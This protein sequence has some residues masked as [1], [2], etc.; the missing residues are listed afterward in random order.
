MSGS[1][2]GGL[3]GPA[4]RD[5]QTRQDGR[6]VPRDIF[7]CS[8][9]FGVAT[10]GPA[11]EARKLPRGTQRR[12]GKFRSQLLDAENALHALNYLW[13]GSFGEQGRE[14]AA[15]GD[16]NY[17]EGQRAMRE[18]VLESVAALG[19]PP[20]EVDEA[21][22]LQQLRLGHHYGRTGGATVVYDSARVS[23]PSPGSRPVAL[24]DLWGDGGEDFVKIFLRDKVLPSCDVQERLREAPPVAYGDPSL[25]RTAVYAEL[26]QRLSDGGVVEFSLEPALEKADVFFVGKSDGRQRMVVDCRRCNA[27]WADPADVA[28][29]TGETLSRLRVPKGQELWC[30]QVDIKDAFWHMEM[31]PPMRRYF[32]LRS[33]RAG[34]LNIKEINGKAVR[35][36]SWIQVRLRALPMGW[37]WA[38]W[39]C[40]AV[41]ERR[42]V[43]AGLPATER[44][45]DGRAVPPLA[46]GP[47][48]VYV[49]NFAVFGKTEQEV[50]EKLQRVT[51]EL[52]ASGLPLHQETVS[53]GCVKLL[54][55]QLGGKTPALR[56]SPARLW[57]IRLAIRWV[58]R[59]PRV[60]SMVMLQLVGHMVFASLCRREML[61]VL[62]S[63]FRFVER[64]PRAGATRLWSSVRRELM[65]WD[66]LAPLLWTALDPEFSEDVVAVDASLWGLGAVRAQASS[67]VVEAASNECERWRFRGR[68]GKSSRQAF[69]ESARAA[70]SGLSDLTEQKDPSALRQISDWEH[71][72]PDHKYHN[73]DPI[74]FETQ[75][76]DSGNPR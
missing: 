14:Q 19:A 71:S 63:V 4:P 42:V 58:L 38:M 39:W 59:L 57:R 33:V 45:A 29:A 41:H 9:C 37:S 12:R 65:L 69:A 43:A 60:S 55:W 34:A 74:Q 53:S 46:C 35:P 2:S 6:S 68:R 15:F 75:C 73:D 10:Q 62:A 7:P 13:T 47:H 8:P 51:A 16:G 32:G 30:G 56:P 17:S 5:K 25:R 18:H 52:S 20:S 67:V 27:H 22:A 72:R 3:V 26:L 70:V 24:S 36:E 64:A 66:A 54:G 44:M 49:D 21:E 23:L 1:G 40:Q 11:S 48:S 31:P 61:S 28:L 50:Q 76:R